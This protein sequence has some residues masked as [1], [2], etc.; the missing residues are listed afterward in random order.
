MFYAR[1]FGFTFVNQK[2]MEQVHFNLFLDFP[3]SV[4]DFCNGFSFWEGAGQKESTCQ[5]KQLV[6]PLLCHP[7]LLSN[8]RKQA[9]SGRHCVFYILHPLESCSYFVGFVFVA[10]LAALHFTPASRS[11]GH[12]VRVSI[13][14]SCFE[15]CQLLCKVC[16]KVLQ[17]K[18]Y[19]T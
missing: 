7:V 14:A 15:A 10:T 19:T 5:A 16:L 3:I 2:W 12:R 4:T 11:I 17:N 13:L 6:D 1:K 9:Y 8:I 18:S